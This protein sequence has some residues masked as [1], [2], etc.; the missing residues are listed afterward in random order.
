MVSLLEHAQMAQYAYNKSGEAGDD[1]KDASIPVPGAFQVFKWNVDAGSGFAAVYGVNHERKEVVIAYRGTNNFLKGDG[2]EDALIAL[3]LPP[4]TTGRAREFCKTVK[5]TF[6]SYAISLTGHSLG[7]G[8]AQMVAAFEQV[9]A[10]TFDAPGMMQA[11][12]V[13]A[14]ATWTRP[15]GSSNVANFR[16]RF[17]AVSAGT[18]AHFG[19]TFS[20]PILSGG[21][22]AAT[23]GAGAA[24]GGIFGA[25]GA[26]VGGLIGAGKVALEA[27]SM[28][29]MVEYIRKHSWGA[30][31]GLEF[32]ADWIK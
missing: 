13:Y 24:A 7:G 18:G 30:K 6:G 12:L 11:I 10:V 26:I 15:R 32:Q 22:A 31:S 2:K 19:R 5:S 27:H 9:P 8:L 29:L 28:S 23:V 14:L 20:F 3:R 1:A 25:K 4:T 17:D 21:K 16:E